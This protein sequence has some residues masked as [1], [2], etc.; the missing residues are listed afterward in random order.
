MELENAGDREVV[1][2]GLRDESTVRRTTVDGVVDTGAVMLV[3]PEDVVDRLGLRTQREV[4]VACA[5]EYRE[6]RQDAWTRQ[7]PR[8]PNDWPDLTPEWCRDH[9]LRTDYA[10]RQALVEIDVLAA[11]A[12]GLTL[13]ELQTIYRVQ[14]PVMRQYE[15]ETYYDA[16][17]RIVFT[18][19]KGL[20][21]VGLPRK[22]IKASP[23]FFAPTT[24]HRSQD[25]RALGWANVG[26]LQSSDQSR[27]GAF[28]GAMTGEAAHDPVY[29]SPFRLAHRESDYSTAWAQA[30]RMSA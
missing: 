26:A 20:P 21:G 24:S 5:N 11:N 12:L 14:F 6:T 27:Q 1:S 29:S 25:G 10:R 16:N 30:P 18:P 22:A 13:D 28:H 4:V 17:G 7:D 2:Q 15:A 23:D 8:L 19:S 3:L 9:A